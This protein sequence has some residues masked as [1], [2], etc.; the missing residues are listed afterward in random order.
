MIYYK[1]GE[2]DLAVLP[3]VQQ[4]AIG[5][6]MGNQMRDLSRIGSLQ[7]DNFQQSRAPLVCVLFESFLLL[8]LNSRENTSSMS[9][10]FDLLYVFISEFE[11]SMASET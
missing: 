5:P 10:L 3:M 2:W 8:H 7:K 1:L 6:D 4:T 9:L 11:E